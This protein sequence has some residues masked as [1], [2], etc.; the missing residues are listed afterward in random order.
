MLQD[1]LA[2]PGVLMHVLSNGVTNA[3]IVYIYC[4]LYL[5]LHIITLANSLHKWVL[6]ARAHTHTHTCTYR[7]TLITELHDFIGS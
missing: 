1:A 5:F 6:H 3:S 2:N 7:T 4:I